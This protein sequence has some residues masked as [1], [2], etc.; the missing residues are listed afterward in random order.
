MRCASTS[1]GGGPKPRTSIAIPTL[2]ASIYGTN[3]RLCPPPAVG[4]WGFVAVVLI[5]G[6]SGAARWMFFKRKRWI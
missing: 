6:G 4:T 3:N 5:M 2:I 1:P